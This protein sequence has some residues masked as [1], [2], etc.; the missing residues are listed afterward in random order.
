MLTFELPLFYLS[1]LLNT[2]FLEILAYDRIKE[3]S[4]THLWG[5]F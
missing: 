5:Q 3:I 1:S 4:Q 2:E